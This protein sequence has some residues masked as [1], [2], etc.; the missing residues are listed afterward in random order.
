MALQSDSEPVQLVADTSS[1]RGGEETG[2]EL[3]FWISAF[4]VA[5]AFVG[6]PALA[7]IL[8]RT[9]GNAVK[10]AAILPRVTVLTAARN[11]GDFIEATIQNKL[12]QNYPEELLDV[13]VVSD[14]STD[15]TDEIVQRFGRRVRLIRQEP[16]AGKT[17]ALN[18]AVKA[19]AGEILVF[20]DANSIYG[21]DAIRELVANFADSSVGYVTGRMVYVAA[22]GSLVGDGCSAYM[23]YENWLRSQE[24]RLAAVI[25]VDGG[26]D[27]V[28]K[29]L[30][31]PMRA[32]QLPDF[33]LPLSV[34]GKGYRV[35][36]ESRALLQEASLSQHEDEYRMRVRVA[37][38][39]LWAL[40]DM[41]GLMNPFHHGLL[42]FQLVSHKLLRYLSFV[43]LV[44]T[45]VTSILLG[46]RGG[47]YL[48]VAIAQ[49]VIY[50]LAMVVWR[51]HSGAVPPIFALPY[52]FLLL[53]VASAHAVLRILRGNRQATW[54]P[55]TG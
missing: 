51:A 43:P 48:S 13:I 4:L 24:T 8:A 50:L 15:G 1:I 10:R 47:F 18:L 36:Y 11:E 32:D 6:Y 17:A 44:L 55:R 38:R 53:N 41:R 5:Y 7:W 40:W 35:V 33:V 19:A 20:S 29:D 30:Y 46:G 16:R 12:D 31:Q 28:R 39:A 26:I 2:M 3:L 52:Y 49:G 37:A 45:L 42:A 9:S 27:A 21:S 54:V 25:G 23:R 14:E 34:A 22:D